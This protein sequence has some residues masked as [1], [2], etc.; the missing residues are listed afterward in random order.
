MLLASSL[1][2]VNVYLAPD[3]KHRILWFHNCIW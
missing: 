2:S 1:K 3:I